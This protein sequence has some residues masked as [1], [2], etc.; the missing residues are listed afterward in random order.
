MTKSLSSKEERSFWDWTGKTFPS[1]KGAPSTQYYFECEK[2]LFE[3]YCPDLKG[4]KIL[5]TD[6][7]D[8][9]KNTQILRWTA[10]EGAQV[11]GIDISGPIVNEAAKIFNKGP[12]ARLIVNDVRNIAFASDSF[13]VIYSMG[14]IEHFHEYRQALKECY[15]VLRPGG[16][17]F[18]GVPNR[19]DP[20]L[21]P[22]MVWLMQA[23]NIYSYGYER[24]FSRRQLEGMLSKT[25]FEISGLSGV[26][27]IPGILR[28][29]DLFIH[30]HA[31]AWTRI[32]APMIHPFSLLFRKFPFL[33]PHSYLI[34]SVARKPGID[35][36]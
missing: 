8:E 32:T 25:G 16:L 12:A 31:P 3:N 13:D 6:L 19:W 5:K 28:M 35:S 26:L 29:L 23:L 18:M 20:F 36:G 2:S 24:S 15:R 11:Y 9:A 22:A 21:R 30:V 27:F 4:K 34:C 17:I 1:L 10:L 7:W 33:R 14:T